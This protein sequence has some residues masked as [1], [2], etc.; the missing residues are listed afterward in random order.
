MLKRGDHVFFAENSEESGVL[1]GKYGFEFYRIAG[2]EL[3]LFAI[4]YQGAKLE[5]RES[6]LDRE[7]RNDFY[8]SRALALYLG[9]PKPGSTHHDNWVLPELKHAIAQGMECLIY[10]S[11]TFPRELLKQ[12]GYENA[13]KIVHTKAE[14][15]SVLL[16]DLKRLV[17]Q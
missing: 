6:S 3:G 5:I 17:G 14:F 2:T 4:Y 8:G 12:Y 10:V 9:T 13:P 15:C 11:P 7:M 1:N 16:D